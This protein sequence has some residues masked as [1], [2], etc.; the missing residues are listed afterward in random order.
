LTLALTYLG[1]TV[2]AL[3]RPTEARQLLEESLA[4]SREVGDRWSTAHCLTQLSN[5]FGLLSETERR[6]GKQLQQESVAIFRELGNRW[7]LT[8][9]LNQLGQISC[10][11]SEYQ[12]AHHAFQEALQIATENHLTPVALD[13][14][15]SLAELRLKMTP[16]EAGRNQAKEVAVELLAVA[17]N[18]SASEQSTKDRAVRLLAEIEA[19]L[20]RSTLT[21]VWERGKTRSL[22][23]VVRDMVIDGYSLHPNKNVY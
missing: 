14:L 1:R 22:E 4:I 2:L 16:A 6:T 12:E 19:E 3:G 23:A 13:V 15:V 20:P 5:L 11:L 8:H 10:A 7:G 17:L 21:K 18:H 9:A